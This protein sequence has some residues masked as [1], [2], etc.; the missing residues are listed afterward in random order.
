VLAPVDP[1]RLHLPDPNAL[2]P[3]VA[4]IEAPVATLRIGSVVIGRPDWL[5]PE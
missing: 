5:S 1:Q 3:A 4:P 2:V